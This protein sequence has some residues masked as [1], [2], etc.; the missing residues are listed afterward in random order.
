MWKFISNQFIVVA[1]RSNRKG[2]ILSNY[3]L[4]ALLKYKTANPNDVDINKMHT[5]Y[6]PLANVLANNY[7]E[8]KGLGG[9]KEASTLNVD[10]LLATLPTKLDIWEPAILVKFSKKTPGYKAIMPKGRSGI[11]RGN[12]E[13]KIVAVNNF[14]KALK[15]IPDLAPIKAQVDAFCDLLQA[16]RSTQLG[17]KSAIKQ[18]SNAVAEAVTDCM[19]MM[20]RNLGLLMDKFA[21]N[22]TII[23]TFFDLQTLQ[24]SSQT[25][26]TGTLAPCENEAILVHTF[27]AGDELRLKI[28]G[29]APALFYLSNVANGTNSQ[30]IEVAAN[31]QKIIDVAEFA[32]ADYPNH[33][34]LTVINSSHSVT[35]KYEVKVL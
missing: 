10:Q 34:Y 26:F 18:G 31:T 28:I 5:R 24:E 3:H 1:G 17:N 21:D 11:S 7:Q 14:A 4:A 2:L 35:T 13:D 8:W 33:R 15:E 6:N 20:Y 32:I 22:P 23:E 19:V 27:M 9:T 30:A 12:K 16:A 29:D 25:N